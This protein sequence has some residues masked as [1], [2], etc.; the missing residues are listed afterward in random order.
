VTEAAG[1]VTPR[2][3]GVSRR[4]GKAAMRYGP[5]FYLRLNSE[6]AHFSENLLADIIARLI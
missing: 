6:E 1:N 2:D 3:A 4:Q 5:P